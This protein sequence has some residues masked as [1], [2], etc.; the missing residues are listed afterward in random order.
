MKI[1]LPISAI[2]YLRTGD[3]LDATYIKASDGDYSYVHMFTFVR[4]SRL[5]IMESNELSSGLEA[6]TEKQEE[7]ALL[8]T[9]YD[10]T[11]S[12]GDGE[13][14]Q[15]LDIDAEK[16]REF[17]SAKEYQDRKMELLNSGAPP[18]DGLFP[19]D[20]FTEEWFSSKENDICSDDE[21]FGEVHT[22]GSDLDDPESSE[23]TGSEEA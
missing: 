5:D 12:N 22:Y 1:R 2:K 18:T 11:K 23:G 3:S 21:D 17:R 8:W 15:M 7:N 4:F 20:I 6:G 19:E 14:S 13:S 9:K 10:L 16:A